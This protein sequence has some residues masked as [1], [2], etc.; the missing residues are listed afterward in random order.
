MTR[1][2]L[3]SILTAAFSTFAPCQDPLAAFD[4]FAATYAT[5]RPGIHHASYSGQIVDSEGKPIAHARVVLLGYQPF[6]WALPLGEA[7][8]DADGLFKISNVNGIGDLALWILSPEGGPFAIQ[9]H[10]LS[11]VSGRNTRLRPIKFTAQPMDPQYETKVVHGS[12]LGKD[13]SAIASAFIRIDGENERFDPGSFAITQ[14]DGSFEILSHTGSPKKM[15]VFMQNRLFRIEHKPG[16]DTLEEDRAYWKSDISDEI[17]LQHA[18]FEGFELTTQGLGNLVPTFAFG[19]GG[20]WN[21]Y[22]DNHAWLMRSSYGSGSGT[23]RASAEGYMPRIQSVPKESTFDFT[24]SVPM[25]LQVRSPAG[26]S[27]PDAHIDV[28]LSRNHGRS[29]LD[30][31]SYTTDATGQLELMSD[32]KGSYQVHVY[33]NGFAPRYANWPGSGTLEVVLIPNDARLTVTGAGENDAIHLRALGSFADVAIAYPP[34]NG[35][36]NIMAPAGRYIATRHDDQSRVV[37]AEIVELVAGETSSPSLV[38][39]NRP[40]VQLTL[41]GIEMEGAWWVR[42]SRGGIGGMISKWRAYSGGDRV[43]ARELPVQVEAVDGSPGTHVLRFPSSGRFTILVGHEKLSQRYFYDLD[44]DF[45]DSIEIELPDLD[46]RL[47][48][49]V[50]KYPKL[51]TFGGQHGI[52]GP[53]LALL[54]DRSSDSQWGVLAALVD[55][56]FILELL[57]AG[58]YALHHHLY[59]STGYSDDEACYGGVL[60]GLLGGETT[61]VGELGTRETQTVELEIHDQNGMA[62]SGM[63]RIRDRMYESWAKVV[64]EGTTLGHALYAIPMP[65]MVRLENGKASLDRISAGRVGF[66]LALDEGG[67]IYF[68]RDLNAGETKQI[69]LTI[70]R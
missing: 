17:T 6:Y 1:L 63:L 70:P 14:P 30:I 37:A 34:A 43:I 29:S 50:A 57:P 42:G 10:G 8:T 20:N 51:W 53:R 4:Q 23:V 59:E 46:A 44:L 11:R 52:A 13:G 19:R 49:S 60:F 32:P 12:L 7:I 26:E 2:L 48:G 27:I 47:K 54:P 67:E 66:I 33:A 16:Q 65:E 15:V 45:G 38:R 68:E 41:P 62:I 25:K 31:A 40:K 3:P 58:D 28:S 56:T 61:D 9:P 24:A 55:E 64:E 35:S 39:D 5:D 36:S 18:N 69:Q 22:A 21:L